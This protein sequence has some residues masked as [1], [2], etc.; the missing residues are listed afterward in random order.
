MKAAVWGCRGSLAAP[1]RIR[2]STA[3]T[4]PASSWSSRTDRRSSWTRGRGS[5]CSALGWR[6]SPSPDPPLPHAPPS[7]PPRGARV[8]IAFG[9]PTA[10]CTSGA[11]PRRL[12]RSRSGSADTFAAALPR[13]ALG[14]AI[15]DTFHDVPMKSS[16]RIARVRAEPVTHRGH[17]RLPVRGNGYTLTYVPDTS[18]SR[19]RGR[20]CRARMA[21]GFSLAEARTCSCTTPSP[22]KRSNPPTSA[23]A[24]RAWPTPSLSRGP[25][26]SS[27]CSSSIT[28]S[29]HRR[30]TALARGPC[31]RAL[32]R[33]RRSAEARERRDDAPAGRRGPGQVLARPGFGE[34]AARLDEMLRHHLHVG[35]DGH[36]VRV[37]QPARNEVEVDVID[38]PGACHS[39]QVPAK[40][41]AL[42]GV[43][44]RERADALAGEAVDLSTSPRGAPRS[45]RRAGTEPPSGGRRRT[46][47]G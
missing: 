21:L 44:L 32:G 38:D 41:V 13:R 47:T 10:S 28:I 1:A 25:P 15:R 39:S 34:L 7:R 42:W 19:C 4:R 6:Q 23:G 22:S 9:S 40:V 45:R 14:G 36:E 18:L 33:A 5:A 43:E 30:P 35:Q 46:G 11:P 29:A 27:I 24:T 2:S 31:A 26:M 37:A 8:L 16:D 12:T 20:R 17:H 3:G